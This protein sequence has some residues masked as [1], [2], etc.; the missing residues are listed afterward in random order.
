MANWF[1]YIIQCKDGSLYTGVTPNITR[2]FQE[3]SEGRGG[4]YTL[5]HKPEKVVYLETFNNKKDALEREKQLKGW[6]RKK[7]KILLILPV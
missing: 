5:L 3:H 7:K 2:R 6:P 1:L 4:R